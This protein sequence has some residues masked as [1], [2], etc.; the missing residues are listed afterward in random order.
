MNRNPR[1]GFSLVEMTIAVGLLGVLFGVLGQFVS[2]WDAARRAADERAF[3]LRTLEN[4]LERAAVGE[5]DSETLSADK[6][7]AA[8]LR[9]P[10]L[11]VARGEL[12]DLG[13]I[14]MRASLSW[15]N[16]QG[17]R[18]TP[19]VLTAWRR[20]TAGRTEASR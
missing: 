4:F 20:G 16:A 18:V 14:P 13:L 9:S 17:Q 7:V 5:P 8:R 6:D 12:D 11:Q 10:Q 2:R 15:Q 3:A 19:V 1:T